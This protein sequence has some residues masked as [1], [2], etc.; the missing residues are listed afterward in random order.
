MTVRERNEKLREIE[1]LSKSLE[2]WLRTPMLESVKKIGAEAIRCR[3][4][5]LSRP[6]TRED[7]RG[8]PEC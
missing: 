8:G 5:E 4:S 7:S 2:S 6:L 3:M 1:H